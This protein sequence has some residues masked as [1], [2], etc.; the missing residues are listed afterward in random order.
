VIYPNHELPRRQVDDDSFVRVGPLLAR[1][2]PLPRQRLLLGWIDA[3]PGGPHRDPGHTWYV[4]AAEWAPDAYPPWAHGA[5]Y[6]LS[7][8]RA[9]GGRSARARRGCARSLF[10]CIFLPSGTEG[11]EAPS[12]R[13]ALCG[14]YGQYR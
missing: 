2:A 14:V 13:R 7:Q 3:D 1:L 10:P 8:A 12:L 6:V 11:R 5:G 4:S 9:A